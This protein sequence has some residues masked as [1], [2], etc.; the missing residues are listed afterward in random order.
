M[1]K[2]CLALSLVF[3]AAVA[4]A[5]EEEIKATIV[6]FFDGLSELNENKLKET[7]TT[8]FILL[9]NGEVWNLDTLISKIQPR[10]Q[11]NFKR[12]NSFVFIN[13]QQNADVAWVSYENTAEFTVND[14][15][16]TVKWLESAVLKK[17]LGKWRIVLLHSTVL[18]PK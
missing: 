6:R 16:R 1:L 13:T 11:T 5:Q 7:T 4:S 10:K 8:D 14:K 9:E 18:N 3:C 15:Q 12:V 2:I 17:Q